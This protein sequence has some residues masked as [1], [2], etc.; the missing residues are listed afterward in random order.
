MAEIKSPMN[1]NGT[2]LTWGC[3]MFGVLGNGTEENVYSPTCALT[4]TVD[5]LEH[6]SLGVTHGLCSTKNG[7]VYS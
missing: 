5:S 3:G 4:K 1:P 2:L 6:V 7:I